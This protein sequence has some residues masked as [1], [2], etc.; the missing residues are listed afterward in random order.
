[1]SANFFTLCI[2]LMIATLVSSC[3]SDSSTTTPVN[4]QE[5][6]AADS[7]SSDDTANVSTGETASESDPVES[8]PDETSP[9]DTNTVEAGDES[10]VQENNPGEVETES[11]PVSPQ[12]DGEQ[13]EPEQEQELAAEEPVEQPAE[14][15]AAQ[16]TQNNQRLNFGSATLLVDLVPNGDSY[17][18]KFHRSGD[19]LYFW[20]VDA[21]PRFA[22]C[23]SHWGSL[24]DV[25]KRI[26]FNFVATHPETG[27]VAMNKR[28]MTL[29]DFAEDPN[30]ACAGY[31]GSVMQVYEQK[32]FT[33]E[34]A[35]D[36]QQFA[37]R[38]EDYY[39]G[40]DQVWM[41][42]GS[43]S[44]TSK[45]DSAQMQERTI[46]EGDKVFIVNVDG[47]WVSDTF[48]G[49][50]RKLFEAVG[51]GYY[52]IKRIVKSPARQATF[53]ISVGPNNRQ[54]WTYD[55]DTDEWEKTFTIKP[56]GNVYTHYETLLVDGE[57]VLSQGRN[58]I[59]GES[60]LAFS[61]N[62]GEVTSFQ[63]VTDSAPSI[64][65]TDDEISHDEYVYSAPDL[66]VEPAGTSIWRFRDGRVENLFSLAPDLQNM[67]II[68]G[69]GDRIYVAGTREIRPRPESTV[70]FEL[71]SYDQQTGQL[72]KLS[73]DDWYAVK[74]NHAIRDQSFVF[75]YLNTPDGLVFVNLKDDSGRELWFTDGTPEG[76]RQLA[77]INPGIDSG[78]PENFYYS[79]D[80][81][82]FSADDGTHGREPWMIPVSR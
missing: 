72:V 55:L 42:D 46:F 18:A 53:E 70:S 39:L 47:L 22:D 5:T 29:G 24:G 10:L 4:S 58:V 21:N 56:D 20:T 3:G 69:Y 80:A 71:W 66:S 7:L 6:I 62:Y 37:L 78:D 13:A 74:Y 73:G 51:D 79:G 43:E 26:A 17:P 27:A 65:N 16:N 14:E 31:N 1:M 32:W 9:G 40:P 30:D 75:R 11:N 59:D 12:D 63:I 57:T 36:T 77:D 35:T 49:N 54:I 68:A 64:F 33:P 76:T 28:M 60:A 45:V 50:R 19:S 8:N 48:S 44:N 23:S 25:H 41:T 67:R 2:G 61:N 82:Y 52:N 15:P 38:F 34:S 81:L